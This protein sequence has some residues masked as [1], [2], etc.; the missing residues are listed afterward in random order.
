MTGKKIVSIVLLLVGVFGSLSAQKI[1]NPKADAKQEIANAV[2][3]A[4]KENKHVLLQ[5]GGN[6][7]PW[8]VKLHKYFHENTAI[9]KLLDENYVF[10]EVNYSKENKNMAIMKS[11]AYPQRFGFPV[12]VVLDKQGN[13]IHTQNTAY[14]EKDKSYDDKKMKKFLSNW[15]VAALQDKMYR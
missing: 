9:H 5:I 14:L 12:L 10:L 2:K 7:C 8:C 3:K 1:Y 6:W 15:R 11:L 4:Q 13:R